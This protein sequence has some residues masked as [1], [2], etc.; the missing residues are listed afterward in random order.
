MVG[1]TP[2]GATHLEASSPS[3]SPLPP[4]SG[5]GVLLAPEEEE[6]D[7]EEENPRNETERWN[8]AASCG[9]FQYL[10]N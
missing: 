4:T 10:V 6:E 2:D 8:C 7:E 9:R 5:D 1:S 3:S